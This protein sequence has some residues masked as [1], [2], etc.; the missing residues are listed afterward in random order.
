M[1]GQEKMLNKIASKIVTENLN[2]FIA[3][4][5]KE[6]YDKRRQILN[7][8]SKD[9]QPIPAIDYV[10][11][12]CINQEAI[13][14]PES[15][16]Q[17]H[18]YFHKLEYGYSNVF[19]QMLL[20]YLKL[21]ISNYLTIRERESTMGRQTRAKDKAELATLEA[22][23]VKLIAIPN[24]F[25]FPNSV[26]KLSTGF[27]ALDN[28]QASLM[29][30]CLSDPSVDLSNYFESPKEVIR[31]IVGSLFIGC[32][33]RMAL[34]MSRIHR[35]E[36]CDQDYDPLY[37]FL[38]ISSGQIIEALKYERMFMNNENY[39]DILQRF[40]E[41]CSKW[42]VIKLLNCLNLSIEEEEV[43]NQYIVESSRPV[44]P[45]NTQ[46]IRVRTNSISHAT[47]PTRH[48]KHTPRNRSVQALQRLPSFNDSPARNTR[49]ARKKKTV[50]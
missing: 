27:W 6:F 46:Q 23:L 28:E 30:S 7:D 20:I 50:N 8:S 33:P 42:D 37:A 45:S 13:Y 2:W 39:H 34:F 49:S 32:N 48:T 38:L 11:R 17:W 44:T 36:N 18:E 16:E 22:I 21:D 9:V 25:D 3:K 15:V 35:Y 12:T 43:L 31:L 10:L 47:T 5:L 1:H 19:Q 40:F 29:I 26:I 41:L 4:V 24:A 14:P